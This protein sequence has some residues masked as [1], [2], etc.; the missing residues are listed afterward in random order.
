M[1]TVD[2]PAAL[3]DWPSTW[4]VPAD[5]LTWMVSLPS[6]PVTVRIPL[7]RLTVGQSRDSRA[8]TPRRAIS[9]RNRTSPSQAETRVRE[10]APKAKGV[11][12]QPEGTGAA[13][14]ENG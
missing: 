1:T 11:P 2:T 9:E 7:S 4:I 14:G 8:S 3:K 13:S 5:S 12:D 10:Y 6:V